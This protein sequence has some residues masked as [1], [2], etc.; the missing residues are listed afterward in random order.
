MAQ[1]EHA[2][3]DTDDPQKQRLP[4][5]LADGRGNR[6]QGHVGG[7]EEGC[8]CVDGV[9]SDAQVFREAVGLRVAKVGPVEPV[10]EVDQHAEGEEVDV[11][12]AVQ[13][14]LL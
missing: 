2:P 1:R 6:L 8:C 3:P 13:G 9:G 7:E 4:D 12:F 5:S 11:Q 14:Q 10:E